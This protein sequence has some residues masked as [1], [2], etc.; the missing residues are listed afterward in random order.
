[1]LSVSGA[2]DHGCAA[3][4]A[5]GDRSG[6]AAPRA[7]TRGESTE[8]A[9]GAKVDWINA[10]FPVPSLSVDGVVALLGKFFGRPLTGATGRGLFGFQTGVK[11]RAY[12]GGTM[13]DVGSLAYGGESQRGRC[14]LQITGNGCGL[15]KDWR[16]LR[17]FLESLDARITRLDLAV[18][19][20]EGQYSVDDAVR[21]HEEGGFTSAGRP[22]STA[23]AGDWLDRV[24]GRTLYIG[25]ATNG[26]MLRVYE[27][28]RQLGDLASAWVRYEVQLGA[29]DREIPFDAMTRCDEY[30]AGCYPALADM[31]EEAAEAI[32]TTRTQAKVSLAHLLQHL[33]RSYGKVIDVVSK[34]TGA[35]VTELV[36]EVRVIGIPRRLNPSGVV[37]G[38]SWSE[39]LDQHR[40]Y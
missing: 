24:R 15:V 17:E 27:K 26:K 23:V 6:A 5:G 35:T 29:K 16:G 36:E 21:M 33:K 22:P 38:L 19:F 11:L 25:K 2:S 40:S 30:F 10:T 34:L 32:P 1:M 31:I 28:G 12:V 7:V 39:V 4:R 3:P 18:D 14:M 37:A 8:G 20:L 13:A 9:K